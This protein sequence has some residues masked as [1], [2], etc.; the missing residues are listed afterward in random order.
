VQADRQAACHQG[1]FIASIPLSAT[2]SLKF[3]LSVLKSVK[4]SFKSVETDFKFVEASVKS[5]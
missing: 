3:V 5:V 1:R 2:K 4:T